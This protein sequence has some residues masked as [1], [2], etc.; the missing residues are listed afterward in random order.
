MGSAGA[1]VVHRSL[2]RRFHIK[3]VPYSQHS[4]VIFRHRVKTAL[5][6]ISTCSSQQPAVSSQP[7]RGSFGW[8]IVHTSARLF[9]IANY[10]VHNLIQSVSASRAYGDHYCLS[11][12]NSWPPHAMPC[13]AIVCHAKPYICNMTVSANCRQFHINTVSHTLQWLRCHTNKWTTKRN[14]QESGR[15]PAIKI[16]SS[17][18][19][20]QHKKSIKIEH[21]HKKKRNAKIK[22]KKQSEVA[23]CKAN[24]LRTMMCPHGRTNRWTDGTSLPEGILKH[25]RRM[26]YFR[27]CKF[28]HRLCSK[29][30]VCVCHLIGQVARAMI[31]AWMAF[32]VQCACAICNICSWTYDIYVMQAMSSRGNE[33]WIKKSKSGQKKRINLLFL[34]TTANRWFWAQI[35][36]VVFCLL[37]LFLMEIYKQASKSVF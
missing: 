36:G 12:C 4:S 8:P 1:F 5:R 33:A 17:W 27:Y 10:I 21:K 18:A 34:Q 16:M 30:S 37:L 35:I 22:K 13:Q 11:N 19:W 14:E 2:Q 28:V 29:R 24:A 3:L 15:S 25:F 31:L 26:E 20:G 9:T 32:L 23:N 6:V 7:T